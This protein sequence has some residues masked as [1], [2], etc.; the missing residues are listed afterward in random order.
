LILKNFLWKSDVNQRI[1]N[2]V[3]IIP[4]LETW[5][6]PPVQKPQWKQIFELT[7]V[8]FNIDQEISR[9][10]QV[11]D[12]GLIDFNDDI[13]DICNVTQQ[14]TKLKEIEADLQTTEFVFVFFKQIGRCFIERP[15]WVAIITK[16]KIQLYLFLH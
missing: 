12:A 13:Q 6:D 11:F 5:S 10:G 16:M 1:D 15:K 14:E 8:E 4:L 9:F 3:E 7:R 2:F